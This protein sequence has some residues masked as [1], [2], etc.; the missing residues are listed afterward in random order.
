MFAAFF[1]ELTILFREITPHVYK[2][3]RLEVRSPT[4]RAKQAH[5]SMEMS[6]VMALIGLVEQ[7]RCQEAISAQVRPRPQGLSRLW[8]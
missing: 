6:D 2:L 3:E 4:P 5:C 8:H 7:R 1:R